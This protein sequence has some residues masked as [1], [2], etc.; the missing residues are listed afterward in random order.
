MFNPFAMPTAPLKPLKILIKATS[1]SLLIF[2]IVIFCTYFIRKQGLYEFHLGYPF[3]F[4]EQFKLSGNSFGNF[5][6]DIEAFLLDFMIYWSVSL[7]LS[8][9]IPRFRPAS[10]KAR[11]LA[12]GK[13]IGS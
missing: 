8:L 7:L 10:R 3:Q 4:Y 5:G 9:L 2:A 6:W 11:L 13:K 12:K 1:V